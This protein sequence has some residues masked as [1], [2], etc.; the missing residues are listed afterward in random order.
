MGFVDWVKSW[1]H[2]TTEE[3]SYFVE[4]MAQN[5]YKKLAIES[6]VNLIADTL[7]Q[8]EFKTY[9]KGKSVK[10]DNYYLWNVAPN[11]N[12]SAAEFRKK[13]VHKLFIENECV[14]VMVNDR[15]LIADGFNAKE[16]VMKDS[17][18][19]QVTVDDFQ[20]T[21]SFS[22]SQVIHLK[23]NDE[24]ITNAING[25]YADY[26]KL[27]AA[28]QNIYKRSNA[29]RFI[30]KG[31][32]LRSQRNPDQKKIDDMMNAQFKPFLEADNAGAIFNLQKDYEL[33]DVSGAGK[34][35]QNKQD[36]RDI[37]NLVDDVFDFIATA[38]HIP[39]GLLK[40]DVVDVAPQV[41]S[42]LM[43]CINPLADLIA[44]ELNKK[45]YEKSDYLSG[46]HIKIDTTNIQ[47]T[48]LSDQAVALDKLF[49]TGA[50]SINDVIRAIGG[51]PIDEDWADRHYVTKNY[52]DA[53]KNEAL[54]GGDN[55]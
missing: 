3:A 9:E 40:G 50:L 32:F 4:L 17:V 42:F 13:L 18:Y 22:E 55:G 19:S 34:N 43:F 46:S 49:A 21:G 30:L 7:T 45:L 8:C 16:N 6:C 1:F 23:L 10:K 5:V 14:I 39:R 41:N 15:L 48:T 36:S 2:T 29:K 25:F 51:E 11:H 27:I 26:G 12:Q 31:D 37:R 54:E 38:F 20:F 47:V 53:T 35:G 28:S 33:E 44:S 52:I 24:K